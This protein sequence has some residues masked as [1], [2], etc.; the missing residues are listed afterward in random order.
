MDFCKKYG[1]A[2]SRREELIKKLKRH[3]NQYSLD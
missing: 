3:E 1:Y 2:E